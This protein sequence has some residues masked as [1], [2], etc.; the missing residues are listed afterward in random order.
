[1]LIIMVKKMVSAKIKM[2]WWV[3]VSGSESHLEKNQFNVVQH[4]LGVFFVAINITD[5]RYDDPKLM[6]KGVWIILI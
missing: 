2:I 4:I 3:K 5:K 1:M 6:C